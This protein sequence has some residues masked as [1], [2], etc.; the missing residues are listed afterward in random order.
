MSESRTLAQAAA[1]IGELEE[2]LIEARAAQSQAE[3]DKQSAVDQ[4]QEA[5]QH[6][7]DAV[8]LKARIAE[9]EQLLSPPQPGSGIVTVTYD[10][11]SGR[12]RKKYQAPDGTKHI[13]AADAL[14]RM[15]VLKVM[16]ADVPEV[17]AERI[18]QRRAQTS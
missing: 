3:S 11:G 9:L 6:A 12:T 18:V 8:P 1:R 17:F 5:V 16:G 13:L 7:S 4:L 15:A 2:Q 14:H 10:D